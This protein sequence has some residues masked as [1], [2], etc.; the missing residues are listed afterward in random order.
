MRLWVTVVTAGRPEYT[1]IAEYMGDTVTDLRRFLA[2]RLDCE[3]SDIGDIQ[4]HTN[5]T[6]ITLADDMDA[7]H[8]RD[9]DSIRVTVSSNPFQ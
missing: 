9:D 2:A 5:G 8:L 3:E 6:K 7:A 1:L 4:L